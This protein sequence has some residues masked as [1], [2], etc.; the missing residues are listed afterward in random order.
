MR[1]KVEVTQEHIEKGLQSNVA[2]CPIALAVAQAVGGYA[3]AHGGGIYLDPIHS[4]R[5]NLPWRARVFMGR[6]DRRG[7]RWVKPFKFWLVV[8]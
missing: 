5:A 6:F 8:P 4:M 1:I 3:C 2:D 7:K